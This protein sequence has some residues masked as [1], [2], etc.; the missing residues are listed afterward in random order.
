MANKILAQDTIV[1]YLD[2]NLSITSSID[3]ASFVAKVK[4][5]DVGYNAKIYYGNENLAMEGM[6]TNKNLTVKN[7]GFTFYYA[8]TGRLMAN[9]IFVDGQLCGVSEFWYENGKK[10]D[11]GKLFYGKKIGHWKF[12]HENGVMAAEGKYADSLEIPLAL[13]TR[14]KSIE[15]A[16]AI[17]DFVDSYY[18]DVNI[19]LWKTFYDNKQIKDSINYTAEGFKQGFAKS[20]Y[21]NGLVESVGYYNE[22]KEENEWLWYYENG[23]MAT[24]E[25]YK[26]GKLFTLECF[27]TTG[28][29]SGDFCGLNRIAAYPGGAT[30]LNKYITKYIQYPTESLSLKK[31]V[32]VNV[33]FIVEKD[34]QIGKTTFG[35]TPNI[36]F[37]KEVERLLFA[38]PKWNPAVKHNRIVASEIVMEIYFIFPTET[39]PL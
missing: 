7:G 16:E 33:K 35:P 28:K 10:K 3:K 11:S 25:R 13:A 21:R 39:K 30:A 9:R 23:K 1:K 15:K 8:S 34:G 2:H 29:Y 4:K 20:W 17:R 19:Y 26:N 5:T 18:D 14:R 12:W 6:F 31:D 37:N 24:K 27:D 32:R 22:D 36:Y 38:M